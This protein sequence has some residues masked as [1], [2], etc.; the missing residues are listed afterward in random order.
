MIATFKRH[1]VAV[2]TAVNSTYFSDPIEGVNCLV[3][4]LKRSRFGFKN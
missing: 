2:L 4:S 3:K 1:K